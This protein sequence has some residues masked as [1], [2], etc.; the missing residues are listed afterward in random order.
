MNTTALAPAPDDAG[1]AAP[2][3]RLV[4]P[5][6]TAGTTEFLPFATA[7]GA[8]V[9]DQAAYAVDPATAQGASA[10]IARSASLNKTWRQ[11]SFGTAA[12]GTFIAEQLN[13]YVADDGNLQNFVDAFVQALKTAVNVAGTA[14]LY[15]RLRLQAPLTVYVSTAGSDS[16]NTG[17]TP[18]SPFATIQHACD[19]LMQTYDSNGFQMTIQLAA[20]TYHQGAQLNAPI[21][22]SNQ[23]NPLIIT[24]DPNNPSAVTV[25]VTGADCFVSLFGGN[26]LIQNM[27]LQ[28]VA[29]GGIPA[30]GYCLAAAE[31]GF[32]AFKNVVFLTATYAHV[33]ITINGTGWI[34]DSYTVAGNAAVHWQ[35]AVGG[36]LI[37][38]QTGN[39][40]TATLSGTRAFST[41]F[42][43]ASDGALIWMTN[44]SFIGTATGVRYLVQTNSV[45]NAYNQGPTFLPGNAAGQTLTGGQ[46]V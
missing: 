4:V 22:G 27:Q 18:G 45:I 8:N 2:D 5:A 38:S 19:F 15:G 6:A 26:M 34:T 41:A 36:A 12:L 23:F 21:S 33:F 17:L 9:V 20:G 3:L 39:N 7:P 29:S 14:V 31:G 1:A 43:Q 32:I 37:T 42:A 10:G 30:G 44:N 11:G 40:V 13:S 24:G 25:N 16:A 35:V 46:Y 28:S